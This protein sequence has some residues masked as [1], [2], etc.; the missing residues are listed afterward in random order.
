MDYTESKITTI[1]KHL[2]TIIEELIGF[3]IEKKINEKL[4]PFVNRT[5]LKAE[6]S[7]KM[8][9][10]MFKDFEKRLILAD[11]TKETQFVVNERLH[12]LERQ[13][14]ICPTRV[15]IDSDLKEKTDEED[16][17][18]FRSDFLAT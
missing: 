18:K 10:A 7:E 8:P 1:E 12:K 2:P 11:N 14:S 13:I 15:E 16:F 9:L 5:E 6:L 17:K 4:L 3:A